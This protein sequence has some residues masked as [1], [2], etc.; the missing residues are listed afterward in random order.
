MIPVV[1]PL[2]ITI[3]KYK[4][5]LLTNDMAELNRLAATIKADINNTKTG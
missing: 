1:K 3:G 5:E 4:S 2:T